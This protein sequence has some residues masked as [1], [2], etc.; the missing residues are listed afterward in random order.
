MSFS[1]RGGDKYLDAI[2]GN[3]GPTLT[4]TKV[5]HDPVTGLVVLPIGDY[6]FD[7]GGSHA[8][9][10]GETAH[11]SVH[12]SWNAALAGTI[13]FEDSN[14]PV[15]RLDALTGPD[16]VPSYDTTAGNWMLENPTTA[17]VPIIG[18]GNTVTAQTVTMGGTN[19]GA[20]MFNLQAIPTRR[21]R[22][23]FHVT[24]SGSVKVAPW[25]KLG[26]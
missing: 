3:A 7:V 22:L 19:A 16:D 12:C 6:Y 2:L 13:T 21:G 15:R 11:V 1:N 18:T 25:G 14:F 24:T 5:A 20:C 4:P 26:G 17:Y 8:S 9:M 23:H 10:P